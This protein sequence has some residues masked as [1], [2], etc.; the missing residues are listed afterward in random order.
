MA[1]LL[2]CRDRVDYASAIVDRRE[3][4][5]RFGR[6]F[7]PVIGRSDGSADARAEADV[8]SYESA[9]ASVM[10]SL[11]E[12]ELF[13]K[14]AE[15]AASSV[16][17][18]RADAAICAYV[19]N[20]AGAWLCAAA[21][22]AFSGRRLVP[23]EGD[24][25]AD[26]NAEASTRRPRSVTVI[27]SSA[28]LTEKGTDWVRHRV[29]ALFPEAPPFGILTAHDEGELSRF[30]AR[31][32]RRE[33]KPRG[34]ADA[35]WMPGEKPYGF[36]DDGKALVPD[37][38]LMPAARSRA[39]RADDPNDAPVVFFRGH[40]REYCG[41]GGRLCSRSVWSEEKLMCIRGH[42]CVA[43]GWARTPTRDLRSDVVFLDNCYGSRFPGSL[44]P[45]HNLT[46]Q[47]VEAGTLAVFG[48]AGRYYIDELTPLLS[49]RLMA[50]G[51]KLGDIARA[52]NRLGN[53]RFGTVECVLLFGDPEGVPF[54]DREPLPELE[55]SVS[56]STCSLQ[57]AKPIAGAAEVFLVRSAIGDGPF[58]CYEQPAHTPNGMRALL[59]R[60]DDAHAALMVLGGHGF[61][62]KLV[63]SRRPP[64]D[65]AV[66]SAAAQL[67]ERLVLVPTAKDDDL[68]QRTS[69]LRMLLQSRAAATRLARMGTTSVEESSQLLGY[70]QGVA[71]AAADLAMQHAR[72]VRKAIE[73]GGWL[74]T[75]YQESDQMDLLP[76]TFGSG[77]STC[78]RCGLPLL[79][80]HYRVFGTGR[81][82]DRT[83]FECERC[84]VICDVL[85]GSALIV[86]DAP[87]E[88][89]LGDH[90]EARV[91]GTND[92]NLPV[93]LGADAIVAY[94]D[95]TKAEIDLVS[96][97]SRVEPGEPFL[98]TFDIRVDPSIRAHIFDLRAVLSMNGAL[99]IANG[100]IRYQRA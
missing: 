84:H 23:L 3:L 72:A 70:E 42:E 22:A 91:R 11:S 87:A 41:Q 38:R 71:Q 14:C 44:E 57:I 30:V 12:R 32:L 26:A 5:A 59:F 46:T 66:L 64:V 78:P 35:C 2:V 74:D 15:R 75:L 28:L 67:V 54:S 73:L 51:W 4:E 90:F 99:A 100:R 76:E 81:A 79:M 13:E 40:S 89:R 58:S 10:S 55:A 69:A 48:S 34:V 88:V 60:L 37:L 1:L 7:V 9:S 62:G 96:C 65:L 61:S 18:E 80:C 16:G 45:L 29:H 33:P 20:D 98:V 27:V 68:D 24:A 31:W 86:I 56:P 63:F 77:G 82:H 52:L 47:L 17:D 49:L 21:F 6:S 93:Y 97:P 43:D 19:T 39:R 95:P 85:A 8:V 83:R 36:D 53:Q 94:I 92:T 25:N 50:A